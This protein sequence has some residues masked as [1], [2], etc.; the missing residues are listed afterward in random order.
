[1]SKTI[2]YF[3]YLFRKIL[4][5]WRMLA[6][7]IVSMLTMDTFLAPIRSYCYDMDI[8]ISPWGFALIWDNKYV[9]LC[10]LLIYILGISNFPEDRGK[11]RYSIAR[12]GIS[13]WVGAQ[14]LFMLLFGWLYTFFLYVIQ[15]LLLIDVIEWSREWGEGW[16]NLT[17]SYI[18]EYFDIFITI[19][20]RVLANYSPEQ[21]N[22][23]EVLIIGLLLGMIGMLV[24]WLNFYAKS[25]GTLAATAV[26]FTSLAAGRY[27]HLYRYS[28]VNWI[29]LE[30]H[31]NLLSPEKP[32][33][34]YIILMLMLLTALLFIL[35]KNRANVTQENNRR[36]L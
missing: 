5:S 23:L 8:K 14:A 18:T 20:K 7:F 27:V 21:A 12:I 13:N 9:G 32:K 28:P 29:Q 17:N 6:V 22:F 24:M 10:F 11:E 4:F 16:K 19:P 33:Q 3:K 31:Y 25:A 35:S 36:K 15:N 34:G 30:N 2:I 26:V 1:M